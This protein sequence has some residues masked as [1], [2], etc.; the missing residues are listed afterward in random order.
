MLKLTQV[1]LWRNGKTVLDGV[2]AD[3][4][5]GQL[6]SLLGMNSAGKSSLLSVVAGELSPGGGEISFDGLNLSLVP[7]EQLA[8]RRAF[9]PQTSKL[10]AEFNVREVAL[11]GAAP[12]T[13][14]AL[15]KLQ[16]LIDSVLRLCD[17]YELAEHPYPRLS[18]GEQ[19]RTQL[20]RVL[21][22]ACAAAAQTP[23]LLLLD[24]P[25]AYLDPYHQHVLLAGLH[26]LVRTLPLSVVASLQDVNLA[27]AYTDQTWL[28]RQGRLVAAGPSREILSP[29]QLNRVFPLNVGSS[30]EALFFSLPGA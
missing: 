8:R 16:G 19:R 29:A 28:L 18:A 4:P 24:E 30:T 27:F 13:E 12:F 1:S 3:A 5:L 7:T 2:S 21:V 17:L 10:N 22:Q 6:I 15:G 20:A 26:Q 9:L 11:L 25:T 14:I 23:A